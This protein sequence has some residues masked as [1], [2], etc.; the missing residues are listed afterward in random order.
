[1][2]TD[3]RPS[4]GQLEAQTAQLR[5]RQESGQPGVLSDSW[6]HDRGP[7]SATVPGSSVSKGVEEDRNSGDKESE[8]VAMRNR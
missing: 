1:M 8:S 2:S 6:G 7:M 5:F 4:A 3:G